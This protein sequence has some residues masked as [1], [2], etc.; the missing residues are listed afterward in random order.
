MNLLR[1]A[2][3]IIAL[4]SCT[5]PKSPKMVGVFFT[6]AFEEQKGD[7]AFVCGWLAIEKAMYCYDLRQ[8]L[9]DLQRRQ[10]AKDRVEL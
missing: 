8:F 2:I 1:V 4:S 5:S 3:A 7:Q 6:P 10:E 9:D